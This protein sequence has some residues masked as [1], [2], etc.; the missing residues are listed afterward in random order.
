[1]SYKRRQFILT[2]LFAFTGRVGGMIIP[3][4]IAYFFGAGSSTD[5][6][7]FAYGIVFFIY[8]LF[9]QVFESML[10]PYLAEQKRRDVRAGA[11]F[12]SKIST[13]FIPALT[14]LCLLLWFSLPSVLEHGSGLGAEAASLTAKLFIQMVPFLLLGV[15]VSGINGIFNTSKVFWFPAFSPVIRSAVVIACIFLF[16]DLLGIFALPGGFVAGE[17][18]RWALSLILLSRLGLW[19][20]GL[21]LGEKPSLERGVARQV[22]FQVLALAAIQLIPIANQWYASWLGQGEL[23]VLSYADRLYA[24]PFQI[25]LTGISQI[26]LA[27]WTDAYEEH[28][29]GIFRKNISRDIRRTVFFSLV[30]SAG[31]WLFRAPVVKLLYGRGSLT[32]AELE[33]ITSVFGWFVVGLAPAIVGSLYLRLLF[34]LKKSEIFCVQSWAKLGAQLVFNLLLIRIAG[35]QGI[36]AATTLVNILGLAAIDWYVRREWKEPPLG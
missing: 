10:L 14:I 15:L 31:F 25:F 4:V 20:L 35:L 9:Q 23:S 24:V 30:L 32:A 1:M 8:G 17:F 3:F 26:F 13:Y 18:V 7:F 22:V 12:V 29:E 11:A 16:H 36:A 33:K 5:A 28:P 2:P 19:K 27:H 34:V 21:T 6:F